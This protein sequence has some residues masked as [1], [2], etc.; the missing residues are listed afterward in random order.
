[1]SQHS[2]PDLFFWW[3]TIWINFH[4]FSRFFLFKI[5]TFVIIWKECKRAAYWSKL[6]DRTKQSV[7]GNLSKYRKNICNFWQV[8]YFKWR[9]FL[10]STLFFFT[11]N[12][13]QTAGFVTAVYLSHHF[14]EFPVVSGFTICD[15]LGTASI[16]FFIIWNFSLF[17]VMMEL[18]FLHGVSL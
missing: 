7:K 1:M 4:I 18:Q 3:E 13:T 11:V 14:M 5:I 6:R 9:R 17:T 16:D 15:E 10:S 12:W 8:R 2:V